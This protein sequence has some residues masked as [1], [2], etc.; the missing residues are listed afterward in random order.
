MLFCSLLAPKQAPASLMAWNTS[1]TSLFVTWEPLNDTSVIAY[2]L[3]Y[4]RADNNTTE[5]RDYFTC[6][7]T[8]LE[9]EELDK[10]TFYNISVKALNREGFGPASQS[11][12]CKTD[13]DGKK[14]LITTMK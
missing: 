9:I 6:N 8:K 13:E 3:S 10:F 11:V 7:L 12:L 4:K 1:S 14:E 2:L 5:T